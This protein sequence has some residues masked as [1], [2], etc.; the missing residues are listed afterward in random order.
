MLHVDL[1][2]VSVGKI[3]TDT[4]RMCGT[5]SNPFQHIVEPLDPKDPKQRFYNLSKLGDPRYDRLP[6]SIRVL[7]ESAVRNCDEFL[8]KKS[9]VESILNWKQTQTQT[10][11][12]PFR[13]ARVILQDFTGACQV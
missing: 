8:V 5:V 3:R 1:L 13:P 9:D 7:L 4:Q 6:F 2:C 11:E 12:V 10:V